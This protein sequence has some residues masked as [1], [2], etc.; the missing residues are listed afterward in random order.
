VRY[1]LYHI[2]RCFCLIR[3]S[4]TGLIYVAAI[5]I[6][7]FKCPSVRR[8]LVLHLMFTKLSSCSQRQFL[9]NTD[10]IN[11]A[12]FLISGNYFTSCHC[13]AENI[14][15][16]AKHIGGPR[17]ENP[18]CKHCFDRVEENPVWT[19]S[20]YTTTW[21]LTCVSCVWLRITYE[22]TYLSD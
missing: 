18:C 5:F 13:I 6:L 3:L 12:R 17:V 22:L 16:C 11:K 2:W 8:V 19:E 1:L 21:Q 14:R 7:P 9:P 10:D 4:V 15:K 20:L